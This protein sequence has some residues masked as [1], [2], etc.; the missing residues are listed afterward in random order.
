MNRL[1]VGAFL[2]SFRLDLKNTLAKAQE[3]GLAGIQLSSLPPEINVEDISEKKAAEIIRIFKDH[4]LVISAVCGDIGG[5]AVDD[6]HEAMIRVERTR[7][8]MDNTRRLGIA[9]VQTHIGFI[10]EDFNDQSV[11]IMRKCLEKIG[12]YGQKIGVVLATE[13]GPEPASTMKRFLDTIQIPAIKVN[14][15]PANLVMNGFD[16][17]GGVAELKD[18]IVHTHAKDG[19]KEKD[20]QGRKEQPLGRGDVNF[21]EYIKAMDAIGYNGF[22]VIEREV[23][24]DPAKDIAEAKRFLDQF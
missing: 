15:D 7:R 9:I 10:P 12:K 22:Y 21:P 6:E 3:I 13:T 20:A 4:N 11:V 23:G 14:Y 19:R 18:Y 5:F 8:I 24:E 16:C 17:I 2:S 1:K